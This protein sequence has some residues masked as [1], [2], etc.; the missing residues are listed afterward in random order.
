MATT[1]K[2]TLGTI[3]TSANAVGVALIWGIVG[4]ICADILSRNLAN[5]PIPGVSDLVA[6]A[7]VIIVF[8]QL[9]A[10]VRNDRLIRTEFAIA[11]LQRCCPRAVRV[12]HVLFNSIGFAICAGI[13][14]WTLP[15]FTK[16]WVNAEFVGNIGIMTFPS[17]PMPAVVILGSALAAIQFISKICADVF[18]LFASVKDHET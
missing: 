6:S 17:W 8:L 14:Y 10:A 13:V 2:S 1:R 18:G 3:V 16:A 11:L 9:A 15:R 7:V 5:K 4:L 12:V